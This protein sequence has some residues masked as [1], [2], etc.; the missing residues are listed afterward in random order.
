VATGEDCGGDFS[1]DLFLSHNDLTDLVE[2]CFVFA[3]QGLQGLFIRSVHEQG[4]VL[5]V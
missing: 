5:S 3:V 2:E 1:N 4:L